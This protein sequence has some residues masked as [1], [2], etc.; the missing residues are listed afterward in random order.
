M[1]QTERISLARNEVQIVHLLMRVWLDK[2]FKLSQNLDQMY[3]VRS[4]MIAS[5]S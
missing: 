3:Q 5:E 1:R 4:T 2:I